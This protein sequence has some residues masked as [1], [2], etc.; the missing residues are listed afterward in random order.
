[1]F[2]MCALTIDVLISYLSGICLCRIDVLCVYFWF[3]QAHLK[4]YLPFIY[5]LQ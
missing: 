3:E 2:I 5:F 4:C 1:M